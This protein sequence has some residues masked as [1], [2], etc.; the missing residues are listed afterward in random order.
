MM[1]LKNWPPVSYLSY[2]DLLCV[3]LIAVCSP[4]C[5]DGQTCVAPNTCGVVGVQLSLGG[6]IYPNN[7]VID[8]NYFLETREPLRCTTGL[9][10]CCFTD[11]YRHGEWLYPNGTAVPTSPHHNHQF[12]SSR[13]D[14]GTVNLYLREYSYD[15]HQMKFCCEIPNANESLQRVCANLG[16]W[17][18]PIFI[19]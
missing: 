9:R 6:L 2:A 11:P 8:V 17:T 12:Y 19:A 14:D 18:G 10:P 7:S 3:L 1:R 16:E 5:P 13:R 4:S 15:H